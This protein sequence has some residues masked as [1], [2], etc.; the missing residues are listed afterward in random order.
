MPR[1]RQI[2][3]EL[4]LLLML[5]KARIGY[6]LGHLA[7]EMDVTERT[8]RRDLEALQEAG[9]SLVQDEAHRWRVFNW[10]EEVA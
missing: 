3:R 5:R 4:R 2:V 9:I 10:R 8:I 6:T 1:N 7:R